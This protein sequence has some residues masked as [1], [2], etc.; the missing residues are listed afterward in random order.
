MIQ[1][2]INVTIIKSVNVKFVG[3]KL[4]PTE[5]APLVVNGEIKEDKAIK[6]VRKAYGL[7][8]QLTEIQVTQD[9]YEISVEDFMKYAK[10]VEPKP[11]NATVT[12]ENATA[13]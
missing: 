13:K 7:S 1:R 4:V 6:A 5:N 11:E 10:K 2:T 8:A 9:M 3:G 12:Q